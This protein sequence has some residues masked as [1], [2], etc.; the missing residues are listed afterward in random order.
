MKILTTKQTIGALIAVARA[1]R[2]IVASDRATGTALT[3]VSVDDLANLETHLNSLDVLPASEGDYISIAEARLRFHGE[4]PHNPHLAVCVK[5]THPDAKLPRY[6]THGSGCFDLFGVEGV[7]VER[8]L[9]VEVDTGVAFEIP[10]GHVMLIFSRSGHG[11]KSDI[12]LS[13]CVG[14]IDSDYRASVKVKLR[15]DEANESLP[16]LY[17]RA[18]AQAIILPFP[19]VA[20]LEVDELSETARGTGGFGSTDKQ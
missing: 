8:G 11:F 5:R 17:G 20:F 18:I 2:T 13:N 6:G 12:R 16:L 14:V 1:A 10:E 7:M 3:E 9:P 19:R 4:Q 15:M